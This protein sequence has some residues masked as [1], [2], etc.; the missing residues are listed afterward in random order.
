[1]SSDRASHLSGKAIIT[2]APALLA[3]CVALG[4]SDN[5]AANRTDAPASGQASNQN[6]RPT[7]S[8]TISAAAS[9]QNAL[10]EIEPLFEA[11][12]PDIDV[13]YNWGG[14]GTLQ[15][16]IEQGAPADIF[17]SASAMQMSAL[18]EQ[19]LVEERS[20]QVLFTNQLVLIAPP[21]SS[22]TKLE[23]LA[24]LGKSQ[25]IAAGEFRSVPAGQ[26]TQAT[27]NSFRLLPKLD[28]KIVFFNNV[29]GV[30][31]AVESGQVAAGFV[32]ATDAQL[33]EQIKVVATVPLPAHPPIEYPIAILQRSGHPQAAQQYVD[34]LTAPAALEIFQ[35]FGFIAE[36]DS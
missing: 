27:L 33:S 12:Y 13:F 10:L 25:K 4:Q 19:N 1:M 21:G 15:R 8:L 30:L 16:Q 35:H 36:L 26:Y 23:D 7:V 6:A 28:S 18:V 20:Q 22:L 34:F 31:S 24:Q 14:S 5:P 9:L 3:S 11:R 32:Y 2:L 29:R 17:F